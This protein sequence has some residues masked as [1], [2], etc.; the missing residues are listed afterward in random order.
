M[1]SILFAAFIFVFLILHVSAFAQLKNYAVQ[2]KKVDSLIEKK[3]LPKSALVEV[4]KIYAQAKK[5]KQEAQI[6][7]ALVYK[8]NLQQQNREDNQLQSIKDIEKEIATAKE[9]SASILKTF[10]ADVYW[11]YFQNQ[12]YQIYSRTNTVN[13][14]KA[15]IATWTAEDFHKKISALYL[16]SLQNEKLLKQTRLE[17]YDAIII[18]GNVRYLRPTLFD[19]LAHHALNYFKN[20]ERD[21][22]KPAYAFE[23][24][25]SEAFAP[26]LEFASYKF[27]T[28]DSLSLQQKALLI[29]QNLIGFHLPDEK[30]EAL[31]DVDIER[32][33]FVY[34][35]SVSE[36]KDSLYLLA[37]NKIIQQYPNHS[38]T[39]EA[40]YLVASWFNTKANGYQPLKDT[41][42]RYYRKTAE[43]ILKE[44]V[45]DSSVKTEAW[46][47]SYN[48]LQQIES[49]SFSF[50]IEK[51]NLP[52]QPFR[53]LV[54]YKN[55]ET[56]NFRL[57]RAEEFLKKQLENIYDENFWSALV[58]ANAVRNWQ[59]KL[60][61][62]NDL[63]QHSVEI[64]ID[65]LPVGEYYLLASPDAQ[66]DETKSS[67]GTQLFY[68]SN[69]SYINQNNNFF[70]LHRETG[71]PLAGASAEVYKQIYNYK[72]SKYTKTKAGTFI[73]DANGFFSIPFQKNEGS[74]NL[75][76]D[77][78]YQND[79]LHLQDGIYNY[80][81]SNEDDED[82]IQKIFFFTDRSIYRPGQTVYF[83]GIAVHQKGNN[84][85]ISVDYKTKIFLQDANAN[86]IDSVIV[87]TNEFGSFNGKFQLPQ[88]SL[89]GQF[90]IYDEDDDNETS[91][92]V[93][94]YKRPKFY[95][96]FEKIKNSYKVNETISVTG[97]AK[98]YAG[99]NIDGAKVSYRV[100]RRPRFIYTW[101]FSRWSQPS[102]TQ[103]E[104]AHGETTTDKDGKFS[105]QFT[106]IPDKKINVAYDPV[107][108]YTLYADVTDINGET[109]SA[110]NT[111]T[112][113]YKSLLLHVNIPAK[114]EADSLKT[115]SIRTENMNGEYQPSSINVSIT[116]L[117]PEQRLIR[118]RY[119]QQ[120]DQ[121]VLSKK[122]Y[123]N[124]F[125]HDEYE[126]ETDERNWQKGEVVFS[127]S[128][129]TK[130][131]SQFSIFNFQFSH[132]YYIVE[133][134]AKNKE[135]EEVKDQRYIELF[136][137]KNNGFNKPEYLWSKGSEPIEP[138]QKTNLQLGSSANIFVINQTDK[139]SENKNSF[140]FVNISN[141]KKAF[142]YSAT[143]A[144]RGGYGVNF[145][146]VKDNR[147]YQYSDVIQVPWTNKQLNI[148]YA[149]FRDKTLPG[150]EEKWKVKITGYKNEKVAAEMLASMYDASL[151]QFKVH[152][153]QSPQI[154]SSY[155]KYDTWNSYTNFT[156]IRSLAVGNS[157]RE[158]KE[159][160]KQYDR[161]IN[162][163]VPIYRL[164]TLSK[165]SFS[166]NPNAQLQDV[167]VTGV[168]GSAKGIIIR[169]NNSINS[170][171]KPLIIVDGIPV[172]SMTNINPNDIE[173]STI[174]KDQSALAMYGAK[175]INGVIIIVTK[176]G[177][178]KTIPPIQPRKNFN[179]TAFFFPDLRTD[180]SGA[181]E[182]SF[183][184]PEALTKWKLQT[185]THTKDLAFG[186]S[187]KEMV[188]QKQLMV[189]PNMPRFLRQNDHIEL[190]TKIVNL[191]DS[192]LT[193]QVQLELF[194]ATTNQSVDGW[195]INTFPNQYFTVA[196]GQSEVVKF[197]VQV[198]VQFNNALVWRITARANSSPERGGRE[199]AFSDGEENIL[200]ILSNKIL[201]TETLPLNMRGS[202]TKN[203]T[204]KK[205]LQSVESETLQ[206]QS[207]TVE[208][209]SN[210]AW[211]AMQALPYLM[212]YPYECAEQTWN[213][214][215]AN[216]LASKIVNAS[217][218]IKQI[219]SKWLESSKV[220][221]E[222]KNLEGALQKNQ[223][224]KSVL[225]EETP[226][227]MQAKSEE[228]QKKNIALL[229]DM[230][231]MSNELQS[232]LEK[233]K[234]MQ[235]ENGGFVWFKG[236]PDDRYTT[237]YI[238]TGIGHLKKSGVDISNLK[239]ILGT[240][241]P[242]LD[243]KI[244]QDFDELI[245]LKTNLNKQHIGAVQIQYLYMRSFFPEMQMPQASQA[246]YNFYKKQTQQFW[247]QQNKY[248]QGMIA[249][250][251]SRMNDKPTAVAILKSLKETSISN[252]EFGMYWKENE[253]GRSWFWW[254]APIETQSLL[255]EAFSEISNDTKTVDNLKTWLLKNKQ[256]NNWQTTKA[257]ADACYAL[258]MMGTNWLNNKADVRIK[259]G[260]TIVDN[261]NS[262][263]ETGIG[264]F[265]QTIAGDKVN[266]EMGNISVKME[267]SKVSPEGGDLEG[268]SSWG[269]AYWQ[270]FENM[271]KILS[272]STPLQLNKKIFIETNTDRGPV[273]TPVE[274]NTALHVGDK[275]KVRIELRVD[276]D[277]EYVHM[278]DMRASA[279]EP[280][281]VLSGYKWQD[282][283][284]YYETTKDASTNFFFD[285]LRKGTYVFEYP[286]FVTHTGTF[287][288]GITTIQCMYAPEFSAH[289]ES[290]R[291]TVE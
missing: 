203:F 254:Y 290:V 3:N 229:F 84:N 64:K 257:T 131:N 44:I 87:I 175:G 250:T 21:I 10:L 119:W 182:F 52:L 59:Q 283:L 148:K 289:S 50:Q 264:Y 265:K 90:T 271:D 233:L 157:Q 161:L 146:F 26:A 277:M 286:L 281:N 270:Y 49:P 134:T 230:L 31:I 189:Q 247:M 266:S 238:V 267:S 97:T 166:M 169:G 140:Q 33:E 4:N 66:F 190:S 139:K 223:E 219:F 141:Q 132:G 72:T 62:A 16:Q 231:R 57:I 256:T 19:L 73:S 155:S 282:G 259:L 151:D 181:I 269:A 172:S 114:M 228:E 115:I 275:I 207:L 205:L 167:L 204:F 195:F 158:T 144:D 99:N 7:K 8:I 171:N 128:D 124:Y 13:F 43:T 18:K 200:P 262:K 71:Q 98:A 41:S 106:A 40:K 110:N 234:Q 197:P 135:G 47:S 164:K 246:A 116:K 245:K 198:P 147:F 48:L 152:N 241:I 249:L 129:S 38:L 81:R 168:P 104:I 6:I 92:S 202:G 268:A 226:W 127:K 112:A 160:S 236:G 252:E 37:L 237:Q 54:T 58:N 174:L 287:S 208:Y 143:E 154:W 75:Y 22:T 65:A 159:F 145:F 5:E 179:E 191:S 224:L 67:L 12:R 196:A 34:Q 137:E 222:G 25:Q 170:S 216:A 30:P 184:T 244:K 291:I 150:S 253:F 111:I 107:F 242:Y 284:G 2:W 274:E 183:T 178:L 11:Q 227:V 165:V 212:E 113:G 96:D 211:Y 56:L 136:D 162:S 220:S 243:K 258:L 210:P 24:N 225:L 263:D 102:T 68:V 218:R 251:L 123:I 288:N 82:T 240:A 63:Q 187:Q 27:I 276:R 76:L 248:L 88:N 177:A 185:L 217:P 14:N 42:Y 77:I 95:V 133:I 17:Q 53:A 51:V 239:S 186:I 100:V 156:Q 101:Y 94:E 213:R 215:Y 32:I 83:K 138:G 91:F 255:I 193:G 60:P 89:N 272:A 180:S 118:S 35:N 235:S 93:E 74:E 125:P 39:N 61:A 278:K 142:D 206:H 55:V 28:K 280:V 260:E 117:I 130:I 85:S 103:M 149:T 199:G 120:P 80:Y 15:D 261:T 121:F 153:W 126:N 176:K 1:K 108:D 201:V 192:E 36:K 279:L 173:S 194:D 209:S 188:T 79:H 221:P 70:V 163:A 9:P 109:R 78:H 23:I 105:I 273:L 46:A 232:N 122:E 214:Y 45:K 29:F 285:H 20:G 86:D 69:I